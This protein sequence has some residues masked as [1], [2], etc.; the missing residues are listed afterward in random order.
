[1]LSVSKHILNICFIEIK[2][3]YSLLTQ[4]VLET[5]SPK[6]LPSSP[7]REQ[8]TFLKVKIV[9]FL[10][11][12]PYYNEDIARWSDDNYRISLEA[13]KSGQGFGSLTRFLFK[14]DLYPSFA[15]GHGIA[16]WK[17]SHLSHHFSPGV[18][19][20]LHGTL[21]ITNKKNISFTVQQF[22]TLYR[23]FHKHYSILL[24]RKLL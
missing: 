21:R 22:L 9:F 3:D 16:A 18:P 6:P 17:D 13:T 7:L 14:M 5:K 24:W 23:L 10:L 12:F 15:H 20:W 1:M 8:M 11:F 19:W 4:W 2:T